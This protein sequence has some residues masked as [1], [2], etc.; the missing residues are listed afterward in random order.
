MV[1]VAVQVTRLLRRIE[2]GDARASEVLVGA[3]YGELRRI[4]ARAM[5]AEAEGLT[6]QPTALVHEAWVRLFGNGSGGSWEDRRHFLN[7][8][9]RAMRHVLIDHAR[10]RQADK[11]GNG[12]R[13]ARLDA[14]LALMERSTPDVLALDGALEQLAE[15]DPEL[16]RLVELRFFAGLTLSETALALGVSTSKVERGWRFARA[17]L[18]GRLE[19]T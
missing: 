4:A 15:M 11:R 10:A 19:P 9:A 18:R 17:W 2:A 7:A 1:Q 14:C 6:L 3:L 8:A 5:S 12:R 16:A 13:A